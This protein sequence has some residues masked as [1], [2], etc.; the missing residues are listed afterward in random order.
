MSVLFYTVA[1]VQRKEAHID[2]IIYFFERQRKG[3]VDSPEFRHTI[4]D[5]F[6]QSA[7]LYDDHIVINLNYSVKKR[8]WRISPPAPIHGGG[9]FF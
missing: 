7:Y 1:S 8:L 9:V 3:D 6:M 5:T 2:Q 4:I